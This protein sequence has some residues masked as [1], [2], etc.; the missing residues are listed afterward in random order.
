MADCFAKGC[1]VADATMRTLEEMNKQGHATVT[2]HKIE[3]IQTQTFARGTAAEMSIAHGS[4]SLITQY[5]VD[6]FVK[7][8][9]IYHSKKAR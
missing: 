9:I 7:S 4:L 3:N 2:P 6:Q 8:C 5:F 1:L